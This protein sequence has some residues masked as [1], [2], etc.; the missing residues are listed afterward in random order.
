MNIPTHI[1]TNGPRLHTQLASEA[2]GDG[3]AACDERA[4]TAAVTAFLPIA[5]RRQRSSRAPA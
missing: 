1:T 2:L 4:A 3:V 5:Y